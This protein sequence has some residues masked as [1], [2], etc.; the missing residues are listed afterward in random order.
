MACCA[1]AW[2]CVCVSQA[3][4]PDAAVARRIVI[5]KDARWVVN[6]VTKAAQEAKKAAKAKKGK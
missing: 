4:V 3:T 5:Q 1:T 2:G 6:I